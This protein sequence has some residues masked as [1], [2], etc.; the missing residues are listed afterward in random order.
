[1]A[2]I[3]KFADD[4]FGGD[5][6]KAMTFLAGKES[7]LTHEQYDKIFSYFDDE[8][9][10]M[11]QHFYVDDFIVAHGGKDNIKKK[12]KVGYYL[13]TM[14]L[15]YDE[16]KDAEQNPFLSKS[17]ISLLVNLVWDV[18]LVLLSSKVKNYMP[19]LVHISSGISFLLASYLGVNILN[20]FIWKKVK[21]NISDEGI[22]F[23]VDNVR[24]FF[25]EDEVKAVDIDNYLLSLESNDTKIS[26]PVD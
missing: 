15:S 21:H 25:T 18:G 2:F 11:M 13:E 23:S 7:N 6:N 22:S 16:V 10:K 5:I 1:M 19:T 9:K 4:K 14:H 17:L 20:F 26:N 3:K 24:E 8:D 12:L